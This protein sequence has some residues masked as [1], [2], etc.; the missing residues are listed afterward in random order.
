[1]KFFVC[2]YYNQAYCEKK[3]AYITIN[4][5]SEREASAGYER[6]LKSMTDNRLEIP[7]LVNQVIELSCGYEP[8]NAKVIRKDIVT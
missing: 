4:Y 1:M 2:F 6:E 7:L 8:R 5:G 3:D